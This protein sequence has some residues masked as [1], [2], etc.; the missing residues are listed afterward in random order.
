MTVYPSIDINQSIGTLSRLALE[1]G[2]DIF[3]CSPIIIPLR[4][5][6]DV[7][8]KYMTLPA[9]R[10]RLLPDARSLAQKS[11]RD[12]TLKNQ[13]ATHRPPGRWRVTS[14]LGLCRRY[15]GSVVKMVGN[16]NCAILLGCFFPV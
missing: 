13:A 12:D 8:E 4:V 9:V 15:C 2:E 1:M 6:Q 3:P 10:P 7:Y 11:C 16:V 14:A 5:L